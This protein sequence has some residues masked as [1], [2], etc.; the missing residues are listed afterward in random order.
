MGNRKGYLQEIHLAELLKM[1]KLII[2][3]KAPM[4][5]KYCFEALDR[6]LRDILIFSNPMSSEQVFGGKIVVF[7]GDFRQ[8]LPV[9]PHGTKQDIVSATITSS[10][11]WHHCKVTTILLN[12]L[13]IHLT[14]SCVP[15][16]FTYI[17]RC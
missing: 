1:A 10:Y 9:V 16:C 14:L 8:I 15:L 11:L 17:C 13:S 12:S 7:G 4:V 6:S 2:W 5:S 3:D